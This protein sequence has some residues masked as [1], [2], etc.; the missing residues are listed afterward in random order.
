MSAAS[1]SKPVEQRSSQTVF[2]LSQLP[3]Q[4]RLAEPGC[5]GGLREA[6]APRHCNEDAY[7]IPVQIHGQPPSSQVR[8][9]LVRFGDVTW[10][11]YLLILGALSKEWHMHRSDRTRLEITAKAIAGT[12]NDPAWKD[13]LPAA[14]AA[15]TC[16][17]GPVHETLA[18][19]F[20]PK[21]SRNGARTGSGRSAR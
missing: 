21:P 8:I 19:V 7:I 17:R 20:D 10:L 9:G 13:Y 4:G 2:Q 6:A 11:R 14:A 15:E 18:Q 1:G 12:R 16:L 3:A 5:A